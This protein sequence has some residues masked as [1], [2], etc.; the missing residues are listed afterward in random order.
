MKHQFTA[1]ARRAIA[2]GA[3]WSG[4]ESSSEL[5]APALLLG[6]LAESECRAAIILGRHG[7]DARAVRR[8]WPTF[9]R[10]EDGTSTGLRE[11]P[12][13]V[14]D[15]FEP[16]TP[17]F[18]AELE[19]SVAATHARLAEFPRP[20]VLA[21]EH[22]L[23]G[24]AAAEHEVA[25]WLRGQGVDA[26]A[27]EAEIRGR[28][29]QPRKTAPLEEPEQPKVSPREQV[30]V[31]RVLDAALNRAREGLRVVEDYVRFVLDDVHLTD[32]MKRL[33]HDLAAAMSRVSL[34]RRL[35]ARET[36]ADVG[37]GLSVASERRREDF[38]GVLSANFTR[39]E[40]SLRTLEE[41]GKIF[42]SR[43]AAELEQLRYRTYTLQRAVEITSDGLQRL[44]LAQ[45]YVLI[46]GG[47]SQEQF[48]A[49]VRSLVDAGVHV[50]QLRDKTLDDRRLLERARQLRR[51]THRS[52]TLFVMNDRPDL[53]ALARADGVHVGQEELTV[54]DARTIVGPDALVGVSIHS[55]EQARQAVLDGAGYLGVG[56]VFASGTKRFEEFPGLDL[57]RAVAGE[58]RLPAFAI[59]GITRENLPEVLGAGFRRI[60][61]SG[62]I[63]TSPDPAA[64]ARELLAALNGGSGFGVQGS[65]PDEAGPD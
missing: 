38:E 41:F 47:P 46:D 64:S 55:I 16:P 42:D 19:E 2:S 63:T 18:S 35:A 29:V 7:V 52:D 60:A 61:V 28:Y 15:D 54:K 44:A 57:L 25:A 65:G 39:L 53:A 3:G 62:A 6:L 43:L 45:L 23:L 27:L 24:L 51:L 11:P 13:A 17:P 5:D 21:T 12:Q 14:V 32:Q 59:G 31:L 9:E 20:L 36:R 49:L 1:G 50:L 40:E 33:R 26:D 48:T 56:P 58:V 22:L 10:V 34:G 4:R 8:R 30:H 37:T